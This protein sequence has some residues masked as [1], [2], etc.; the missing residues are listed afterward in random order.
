MTMTPKSSVQIR[1]I[2]LSNRLRLGSHSVVG[3]EVDGHY[4][5]LLFGNC[6][7]IR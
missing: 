1:I 7:F 4:F 6:V 5:R 2:E 3:C